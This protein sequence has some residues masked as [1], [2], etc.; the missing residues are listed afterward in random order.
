MGVFRSALPIRVSCA[1]V[2]LRCA[3]GERD[4]V[5]DVPRNRIELQKGGLR[6]SF[7]RW[8]VSVLWKERCMH[9]GPIVVPI[10][11]KAYI[12]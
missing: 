11:T 3:V 5:R 2:Q 8:G 9:V 1:F 6:T 10:C 7:P 4:D 12:K